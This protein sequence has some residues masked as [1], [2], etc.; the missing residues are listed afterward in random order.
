M[1]KMNKKGVQTKD[2]TP[3][4][5]EGNKQEKLISEKNAPNHLSTSKSFKKND[6][7]L[8]HV[9]LPICFLIIQKKTEGG[10]GSTLI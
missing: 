5:P 1:I 3:A 2:P 8:A 7:C 10:G 6:L 4:A 9:V